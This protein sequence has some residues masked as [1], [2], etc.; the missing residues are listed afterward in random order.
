MTCTNYNNFVSVTGIGQNYLINQLEDNLKSYLDNG[1]LNIGAF[2]NIN[3]PTS[4]INDISYHKLRPVQQP[5]YANYKVWQSFK[6][7]W[8]WETGIQYNGTSPNKIS[9][10]RINNTLYAAP[11][12]SGNFTYN[13]NYPLGNVVFNNALPSGTNMELNYSYRWCQVYKSSSC[14]W[15]RELQ[16]STYDGT[17]LE[18]TDRGDYVISSQH[19]VQMPCIIIEPISRTELIPYQLGDNSFRVNQDIMLHIFSDN[20]SH[21]NDIVDI[22]RLQKNKVLSFYDANKIR[23]IYGLDYK[24]SPIYSGYNY[25]QIINDP[26][27]DWKSCYFVDIV[28]TDMETLNFGLSWCTLRVTAEIII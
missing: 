14:S 26:N 20:T 13:I 4:G 16:K 3:S 2:I 10:I 8:V 24:G 15:W 21:K 28:S 23:S 7:D 9:G 1:F 5:G 6:K 17:Q 25:H 22:I 27:Y 12:G 19:R 18:K 11:T